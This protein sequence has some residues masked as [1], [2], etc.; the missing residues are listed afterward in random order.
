[1]SSPATQVCDGWDARL[2]ASDGSVVVMHWPTGPEP[3]AAVIAAALASYDQR[4]ADE[5]S[6]AEI[7]ANMQEVEA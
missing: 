7:E 2:T 6:A 5:A 4:L 3:S 1:M